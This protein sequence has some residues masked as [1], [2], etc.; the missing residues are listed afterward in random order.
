M[1]W[2][3]NFIIFNRTKQFIAPSHLIFIKKAFPSLYLRPKTKRMMHGKTNAFSLPETS[4]DICRHLTL[5]L[6]RKDGPTPS[7]QPKP[8]HVDVCM[9]VREYGG[10]VLFFPSPPSK[11]APLK[12]HHQRFCVGGGGCKARQSTTVACSDSDSLKTTSTATASVAVNR[13]VA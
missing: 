13:I 12:W 6:A 7:S 1:H 2:C 8:R 3:H 9:C 4:K 10:K 5:L 11:A